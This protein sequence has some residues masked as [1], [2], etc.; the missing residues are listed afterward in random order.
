MKYNELRKLAKNLGLTFSKTPNRIELEAAVAKVSVENADTKASFNDPVTLRQQAEALR[1]QADEIAEQARQAEERAQ[2]IETATNVFQSAKRQLRSALVAVRDAIGSLNGLGIEVDWPIS[3]RTVG[4]VICDLTMPSRVYC[5]WAEGN[6]PV[7]KGYVAAES[8]DEAKKRV[9]AQDVDFGE[10]HPGTYGWPAAAEDTL[11][12]LQEGG[13]A[14]CE[15]YSTMVYTE[16]IETTGIFRF[17]LNGPEYAG[18]AVVVAS[19]FDEAKTKALA[20]D[21][22]G[23][24]ID[25]SEW[26]AD[27]LA[28]LKVAVA[29]LTENGQVQHADHVLTAKTIA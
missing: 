9:L 18:F 8:F 15:K 14:W 11:R 25:L 7:W 29:K 16:T 12:K 21:V 1:A 23:G 24:E 19:S 28:E 26:E 10:T 17:D 4:K 5:F 20:E 13:D 27:D 2:A 3:Q 22:I 6:Y